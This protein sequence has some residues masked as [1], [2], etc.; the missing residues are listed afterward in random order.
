[1]RGEE[2]ESK[3]FGGTEVGDAQRLFDRTERKANM[4]R[5]SRAQPKWD[6]GMNRELARDGFLRRRTD[7][8]SLYRH[9]R[10]SASD[11]DD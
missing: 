10:Q 11:M 9:R 8:A 4:S 5:H 2:P 6:G 3:P 1:M 7:G